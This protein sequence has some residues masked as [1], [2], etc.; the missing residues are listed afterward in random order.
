MNVGDENVLIS[1]LFLYS[2]LYLISPA[3][4]PDATENYQMI[5]TIKMHVNIRYDWRGE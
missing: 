2:T 3:Q 4:R 1:L 5:I